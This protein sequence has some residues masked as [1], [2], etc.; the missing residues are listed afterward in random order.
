MRHVDHAR[1]GPLDLARAAA[2]ASVVS[3]RTGL[4]TSRVL[5]GLSGGAP[6]ADPRG[7]PTGGIAELAHA[8]S[9]PAHLDGDPT[10]RA[11]TVAAL[12]RSFGL[13]AH[14][15]RVRLRQ[16]LQV[17]RDTRQLH[18]PVH[19]GD[20]RLVD[21]D[22]TATHD[23]GVEQPWPPWDVARRVGE[24]LDHPLEAPPQVPPAPEELPQIADDLSTVL[25][26]GATFSTPEAAATV[27][28]LADAVIRIARAARP[29]P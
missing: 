16:V 15:D 13:Q 21:G 28:A 9:D 10:A 12:L 4:P 20:A 7:C 8:A 2:A 17:D 6:L 14:L 18:L 27:T 11:E 25:G 23:L 22:E 26:A 1:T 29:A 19:G 24:L 3:W 5:A